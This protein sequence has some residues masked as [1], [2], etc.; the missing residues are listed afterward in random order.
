MTAAERLGD[1]LWRQVTGLWP[2]C[3]SADGG[4]AG[5]VVRCTCSEFAAV[6]ELAND[7]P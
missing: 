3:V 1:G 6:K 4:V 7:E 5:V 2:F